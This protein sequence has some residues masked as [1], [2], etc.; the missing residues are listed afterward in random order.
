MSLL[1]TFAESVNLKTP[2]RITARRSSFISGGAW[3]AL[4]A[5][6]SSKRDFAI[7]MLYTYSGIRRSECVNLRLNQVD[8][9]AKEIYVIGKGDKQRTVYLNEKTVHAIREYLKVRRY[10]S[11]YLFVSRQ[12]E[13]LSPLRINQIFNQYSDVITPKMLRHYFCSHR[14]VLI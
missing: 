4:A 2:Y 11:P 8:L 9:I 12:S 1:S 13:K 3:T 14:K 7:V 10:E 6:R 5:N